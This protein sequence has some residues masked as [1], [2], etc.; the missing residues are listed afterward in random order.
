MKQEKIVLL[1]IRGAIS[2]APADDREKIKAAETEIRA[3]VAKYPG[4]AQIAVA[5]IGAEI[6]AEE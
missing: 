3:V 5:L 2:E 4:H 1:M 6:A